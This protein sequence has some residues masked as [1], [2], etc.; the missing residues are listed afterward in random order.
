MRSCGAL[1]AA[2]VVDVAGHRAHFAVFDTLRKKAHTKEESR[3][4]DRLSALIEKGQ[5]TPGV[6]DDFGMAVWETTQKIDADVVPLIEKGHDDTQA[7][8]SAAVDEVEETTQT[9]VD[10]KVT[11]DGKDKEW[12]DC[13]AQEKKD[14]EAVEAAEG[15]LAAA[16]SRVKEPCDAETAAE[17]FST[18]VTLPSFSC[19][20]EEQDGQ[21]DVSKYKETAQD[22][23]TEAKND[24]QNKKQIYDDAVALCKEAHDNVTTATAERNSAITTWSNQQ[25]SCVQM[26][27]DRE[28]AICDFGTALKG[29]CAAVDAYGVLEEQVAGSD[30]EHSHSDRENEYKTA[31][32]AQ[33]LIRGIAA[34]PGSLDAEDL[35]ACEKEVI[36]MR[37]LDWEEADFGAATVANKFTC[38][39]T[40]IEFTGRFWNSPGEDVE[41]PSSDSYEEVVSGH[42]EPVDPRNSFSFCQGPLGK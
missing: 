25:D 37:A 7:A 39:E 29:K 35:A 3:L 42:V 1:L 9:A 26:W 32:I 21:C 23:L 15:E 34:N 30:N 5:A 22:M 13:I 36:P 28:T 40:A 20:I 10:K 24:Q 11:A 31:Q 8:I 14:R 41:A 17:P 16:E 6:M 2:L 38:S 12:N 27:A 18:Q 33:C 19:D 4:V